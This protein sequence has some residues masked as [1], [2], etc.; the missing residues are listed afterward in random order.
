MRK[1]IFKKILCL[2]FGLGVASAVVGCA[3][4]EDKLSAQAVGTGEAAEEECE[5]R[6][7]TLSAVVDYDIE[8]QLRHM[9]APFVQRAG[10]PSTE[11]YPLFL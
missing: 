4:D 10:H 6:K 7:V 3:K 1:E 2:G 8:E 9:S 11:M 5:T